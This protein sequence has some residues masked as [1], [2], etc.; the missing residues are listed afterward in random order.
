[1]PDD[2]ISYQ[3]Q[4]ETVEMMAK[5]FANPAARKTMRPAPRDA[6]VE[7][8]LVAAAAALATLRLLAHKA[9]EGK[10]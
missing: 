1:M 7:A 3:R 2:Q 9:R 4:A 6:E 8:H 5:L 10:A